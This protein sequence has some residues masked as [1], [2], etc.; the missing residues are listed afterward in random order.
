MKTRTLLNRLARFL[1]ADH[2]AQRAEMKSI[3]EVLKKLKTKETHLR[4]ALEEVPDE[5]ERE[6]ILTKLDVVHAQRL[7]GLARVL[8]LREE[9]KR[10]KNRA[11]SA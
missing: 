8:E 10:G 7:K 4:E 5:D 6:A 2:A 9:K 1:S 11:E 3:R